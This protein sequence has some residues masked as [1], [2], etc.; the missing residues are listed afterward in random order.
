M[1]VVVKLDWP[2][3]SKSFELDTKILGIVSDVLWKNIDHFF[4]LWN[5]VFLRTGGIMY[6]NFTKMAVIRGLYV[7]NQ[8]IFAIKIEFNMYLKIPVRE[9]GDPN[10]VKLLKLHKFWENG[11]KMA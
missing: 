11:I 2:P 1:K 7:E 5:H 3:R 4:V 8:I 6:P 10:T 9:T